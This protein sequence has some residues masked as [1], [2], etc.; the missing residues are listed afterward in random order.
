IET[1]RS[2]P[3]GPSSGTSASA[4]GI[5]TTSPASAV[6]GTTAAST[7]NGD[8][9]TYGR[10][11]RARR[12]MPCDPAPAISPTARGTSPTTR[13]IRDA[14]VPPD[15]MAMVTIAMPA[16][17]AIQPTTKSP[18]ADRPSIVNVELPARAGPGGV[19]A[20]SGRGPAGGSGGF[21]APGEDPPGSSS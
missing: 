14:V 20:S 5:P 15:R 17:V 10:T 4:N 11:P 2:A 9:P 18:G 3:N 7:R 19:A 12:S 16:S 13:R 21:N 6:T 1:P 8:G